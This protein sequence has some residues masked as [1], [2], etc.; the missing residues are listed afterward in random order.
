MA[1]KTG[2]QSAESAAVV[3]ENSP[4][5]AG[6]QDESLS[7]TE[8]L[9]S[10]LI[11]SNLATEAGLH[12]ER[13]PGPVRSGERQPEPDMREQK[14]Q[15]LNGHISE[16]ELAALFADSQND[17][18]WTDEVEPQTT[19]LPD[20]ALPLPMAVPHSALGTNPARSGG[21]EIGSISP[22]PDTEPVGT[23]ESEHQLSQSE[24][25]ALLARLMGG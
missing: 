19:P 7:T 20:Q 10:S 17:A 25:D 1:S 9:V 13:I 15:P 12:T 18:I 8:A 23:K 16:A 4:D 14:A 3:Q 22:L 5:R 24:I 21:G 6:R 2:E 11:H